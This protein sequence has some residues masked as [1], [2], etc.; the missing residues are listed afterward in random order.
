MKKDFVTVGGLRTYYWQAGDTGPILFMLHGQLPGSCVEVEWGDHVEN[1][2]KAGFRVYAPDVAGFGQTDNPPD[3]SLDTRVAHLLAFADHF[4]FDRYSVWGSSMGSYMGCAMALKDPR[5]DKLILMPSTVLP[6]M[7]DAA[8]VWV[9][10]TGSVGELV[11]SYTPTPQKARVLLER[12]NANKAAITDELVRVFVENS[13][14]KNA[15][16]LKGRLALG[17]PKPL[18]PELKTLK[19]KALLLWGADDSPDRALLLQR[20]FPGSELHMFPDCQHWPQFDHPK[21]SFEIVS[22]FLR[23]A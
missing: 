17:R 19:N 10:Q 8:P 21:R 1:F 20:A 22:A 5:L 13:S 23:Q 2:G 9:V 3:Y 15:E 16:A 18:H 14:G 4:K 6:P 12:A 11:P 7:T